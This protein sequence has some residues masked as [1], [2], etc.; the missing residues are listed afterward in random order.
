MTWYEPG[1]H[2]VIAVYDEDRKLGRCIAFYISKDLKQ[3]ELTGK[4]PGYY[5]CPELI[6]LPVDGDPKNKR[7]VLF[8]ADA[9]YAIGKFNGRIFIPEHKGKYRVHWGA[10]YASQCFS[11]SPDG[12]AV[13]IGWAKINMPGMPFNQTFSLPTNLTLRTTAGGIRMF[14][15]P[16]RELEKLR[17]PNPQKV[18]NYKLT[19]RSPCVEFKVRDQ[20]FDIIV[21]VKRVSA[22]KVVLR[23]GKNAVTYDFRTKRL[24]EMPLPTKNGTVRFRVLIDRRMY[25]IV[26]G[27]GNCYKTSPRFDLGSPIG[28]VS[29]TAEGGDAVVRSFVI[30][31]MRSIWRKN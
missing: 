26:G 23:F 29:L 20:L 13:Q 1:K 2:W 24:D 25:E 9:R 16:I 10:Y 3:W 5:E 7:W 11:N 21:L 18:Q 19:E 14:A 17:K 15:N 31:E 30:Y 6:E 28:T 8:A 12:R 27:N 22:S 4:I